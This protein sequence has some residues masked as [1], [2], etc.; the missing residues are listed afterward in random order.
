MHIVRRF[1]FK[2]KWPAVCVFATVIL[3]SLQGR[4]LDVISTGQVQRPVANSPY[5]FML[6]L[7]I[8]CIFPFGDDSVC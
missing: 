2:V 4:R 6:I 1:I 5:I 8:I 7:N 3:V